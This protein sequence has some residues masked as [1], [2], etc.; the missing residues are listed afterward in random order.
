[1]R[2]L[3]PKQLSGCREKWAGVEDHRVIEGY[4]YAYHSLYVD[5]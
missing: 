5:D 2:V 1:M 4:K 3:D